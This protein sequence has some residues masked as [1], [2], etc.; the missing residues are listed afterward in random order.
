MS[1]DELEAK[2]L[3]TLTEHGTLLSNVLHR[4]IGGN[5]TRY[6]KIRDSMIEQNIIKKI[7]NHRM[8]LSTI[9]I[10]DSMP[11]RDVLRTAR[12]NCDTY[13]RGLNAIKPITTK[14]NKKEIKLKAKKFLNA[15]F[16]QLEKVQAIRIRLAYA[17]SFGVLTKR[18]LTIDQKKCDEFVLEILEKLFKEHKQFEKEIIEHQKTQPRHIKFSV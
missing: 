5:K 6:A 3:Q 15:L 1:D 8:Y 13:L 16:M 17:H 4:K 18:T 9:S 11:T 7:G 2:I 12:A 10:R 14:K